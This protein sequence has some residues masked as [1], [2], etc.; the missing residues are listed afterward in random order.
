MAMTTPM[1]RE[2]AAEGPRASVSKLWTKPR[3]QKIWTLLLQEEKRLVY[4]ASGAQASIRI[5]PLTANAGGRRGC[6][7]PQIGRVEGCIAR[8]PQK[9]TCTHV[10]QDE[11]AAAPA[12]VCRSR[13]AASLSVHSRAARR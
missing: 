6:R 9:P 10:V 5:E 2:A 4:A 13:A 7:V 1:R 11:R 8:V 12:C 3:S